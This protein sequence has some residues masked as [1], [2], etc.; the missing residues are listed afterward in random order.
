MQTSD[1]VQQ[2]LNR[3]YQQKDNT[4]IGDLLTAIQSPDDI[5]SYA[6]KWAVMKLA[7]KLDGRSCSIEWWCLP[8][9]RGEAARW[10]CSR[11]SSKVEASVACLLQRQYQQVWTRDLLK[12]G[13]RQQ[14]RDLQQ[15]WASVLCCVCKHCSFLAHPT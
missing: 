3:R 12:S 15:P 8:A 7:A 1:T 14:L 13:R 9:V 10:V 2:R 4:S 6:F 5:R 11:W